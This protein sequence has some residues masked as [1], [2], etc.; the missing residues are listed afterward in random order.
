MTTLS[1]QHYATFHLTLLHLTVL[2]SSIR[3]T[4]PFPC[5]IPQPLH[6]RQCC[7]T[8]YLSLPSQHP[9]H[10]IPPGLI[11]SDWPPARLV[12]QDRIVSDWP[13]SESVTPPVCTIRRKPRESPLIPLQPP[14]SQLHL[15]PSPPQW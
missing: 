11:V 15:D 2:P 5:L 9:A 13:R 6:H 8:P 7:I 14:L 4:M 3:A 1:Y 12:P 10:L